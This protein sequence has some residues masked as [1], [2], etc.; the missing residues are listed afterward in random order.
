MLVKKWFEENEP[1]VEITTFINTKTVDRLRRRNFG[2]VRS[3]A[4]HLQLSF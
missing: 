3:N 1:E 4:L 2:I